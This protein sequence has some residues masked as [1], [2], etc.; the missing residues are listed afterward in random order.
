MVQS[1]SYAHN[2][3]WQNLAEISCRLKSPLCYC[4][5]PPSVMTVWR[6]FGFQ[7]LRSTNFRRILPSRSRNSTLRRPRLLPS[8]YSQCGVHAVGLTHNSIF[9][10]Y[11]QLRRELL[12]LAL[13]S[14]ILIILD[15]RGGHKLS[16]CFLSS[17]AYFISTILIFI[18]RRCKS[19]FA[20]LSDGTEKTTLRQR[21]KFDWL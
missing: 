12:R 15:K 11:L 5:P 1:S 13:T 16:K 17:F 18:Y 19:V 8:Q 4:L 9:L 10:G 3:F 6:R 21:H 20:K 14:L 7:T 2:R